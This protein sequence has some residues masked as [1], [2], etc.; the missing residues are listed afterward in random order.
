MVT[1]INSEFI[2]RLKVLASKNKDLDEFLKENKN[3]YENISIIKPAKKLN[4]VK[5]YN[6]CKKYFEEKYKEFNNV[7]YI[8]NIKD[9]SCIE[10]YLKQGSYR[11]FIE[12]INFVYSERINEIEFLAD[13]ILGLP[14]IMSVSNQILMCLEGKNKKRKNKYREWSDL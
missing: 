3:L 2:D 8:F 10:T 7:S 1:I 4:K 14:L 13:K 9:K 6:L 11:Q 5:D 12:I